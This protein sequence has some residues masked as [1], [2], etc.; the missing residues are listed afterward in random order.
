MNLFQQ[1]KRYLDTGAIRVWLKDEE[2]Y[3][4]AIIQDPNK[5]FLANSSHGE[6]KKDCYYKQGGAEKEDYFN[7]VFEDYKLADVDYPLIPQF[8]RGE[9]VKF[10][11]NDR[12]YTVESQS[13]DIVNLGEDGFAGACDLELAFPQE[14]E[15]PL[16][17][18]MDEVASKFGVKSIKIKKV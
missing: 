16:E 3:W 11:I 8:K 7:E 6:N 15:E 12:I 2:G 4:M 18:T 1:C 14:E 17:V 5:E 13:N 10:K 9:K